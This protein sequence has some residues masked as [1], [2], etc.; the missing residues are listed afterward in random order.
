M[1]PERGGRW[2]VEVSIMTEA[3]SKSN[4]Q[5]RRW[6]F[7]IIVIDSKTLIFIYD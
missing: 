1:I 5:E 2:Y 6:N 3:E 7:K 4:Y